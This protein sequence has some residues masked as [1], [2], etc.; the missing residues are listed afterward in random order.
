MSENI[1]DAPEW[2][3]RVWR[4]GYRTWGEAMDDWRD[5]VFTWTSHM[6]GDI[7]E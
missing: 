5:G 1:Y 3:K 6:E 2:F 4:L 7:E